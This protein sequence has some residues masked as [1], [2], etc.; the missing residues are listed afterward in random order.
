M[1]AYW[2]IEV[3][4]H[5][6]TSV[7]DGSEWSALRPGRFTPKKSA[8]GTHWTGGWVG[9]RAGLDTVGTY[10]YNNLC[11]HA[12]NFQNNSHTSRFSYVLTYTPI[13]LMLSR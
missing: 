12:C 11:V 5:A 6:F 8:P 4:L 9:P 10:V 1:R 7:L 3:Y 13:T 2:G